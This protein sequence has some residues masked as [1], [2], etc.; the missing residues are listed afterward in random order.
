MLVIFPWSCI[1]FGNKALCGTNQSITSF[2]DLRWFNH[3]DRLCTVTGGSE[4]NWHTGKTFDQ[5][6][7]WYRMTRISKGVVFLLAQ[8]GRRPNLHFLRCSYKPVN[9]HPQIAFLSGV[10]AYNTIKQRLCF[11]MCWS[12]TTVE[13]SQQR[14][15]HCSNMYLC[16]CVCMTHSL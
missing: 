9:T 11:C 3:S 16:V 4:V 5:L 8:P 13:Q 10:T 14:H 12:P 6:A 2:S 7:N 15:T 1:F